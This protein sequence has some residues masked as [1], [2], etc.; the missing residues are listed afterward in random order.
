M[1]LDERIVLWRAGGPGRVC[2]QDL[3][4]HRGS[5]FSLGGSRAAIVLR[6]P[7]VAIRQPTDACPGI[8][9]LPEGRSIPSQGPSRA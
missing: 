8:P 4:I 3:C 5:A 2:L 9:S 1:L 6:L 7:R